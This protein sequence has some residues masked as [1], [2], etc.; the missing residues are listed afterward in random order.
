MIPGAGGR[1]SKNVPD[2]L[3]LWHQL[4]VFSS[5]TVSLAGV[6]DLGE[7][8]VADALVGSLGVVADVGTRTKLSALVFI[9]NTTRH[10]SSVREKRF[11]VGKNSVVGLL[12]KVIQ[13]LLDNSLKSNPTTSFAALL[14]QLVITTTKKK[15]K[16]KVDNVFH[17]NRL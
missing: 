3:S 8:L 12:H 14:N 2:C 15:I 13:Q 4:S 17:Y 6:V 16:K 10:S 1:H 5:L 9:C 7:V 11:H